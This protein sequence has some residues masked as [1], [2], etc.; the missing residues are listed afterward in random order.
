MKLVT[1]IFARDQRQT[2]VELDRQISELIQHV[3]DFYALLG[4][5]HWIYHDLL[6][7]EEMA[8]VV[9]QPVDAAERALIDYYKADD[10]LVFMTRTLRSLS[11]MTPRMG[12]IERAQRD[13]AAGRY[14]STVL[15][16]IA[17][18][19]GFVN[20]IDT[21]RRR[22][23]HAR[24]DD[25]MSAWDSVVGH[26]LGLAKAHRTFT[27][28]FSKTS[29]EE[30]HELYRNGIVHGT[31]TN[32][33]NDIVATKAWN[34]LF[35]VADWAKSAKKQAKP[36]EPERSWGDLLKQVRQNATDREI[37]DAWKP[38]TLERGDEGFESDPVYTRATEYLI[39][40]KTKNYGKMASVLAS[41]VTRGDSPGKLAGRVRDD[42]SLVELEDFEIT[43]LDFEAPV[44]CEVDV[45]LTADGQTHAGRMR[46]IREDDDGKPVLSNQSGR[47]RLICWGPWAMLTPRKGN[48]EEEESGAPT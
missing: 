8:K 41:L 27:K 12:L 20:D 23:L 1:D 16:L 13:Y 37:V 38:S 39:A 6:N 44:I 3:D 34:R 5:R 26:H 14:Y 29:D 45:D 10:V 35:A 22:G 4:P 30:V 7:T 21:S 48:Q 47:W 36:R 24:D 33:D 46:W 42:Y 15:L 32:F 9:A 18:M 25:E 19:D 43:R 17:V 11:E 40:W 2:V 31:L 28:T